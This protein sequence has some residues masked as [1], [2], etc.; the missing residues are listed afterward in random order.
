M[1]DRKKGDRTTLLEWL[2]F[3]RKLSSQFPPAPLRVLYSASGKIPAAALLR[4][5]AAVIEHKLYWAPVEREEEGLYLAAILNSDQAR[6]RVE[7]Q[8]SRGQ[9]GP[10]DFDNLLVELPIPKFDP[11]VSVHRALVAA[12]AEAEE[13]AAGVSIP[14]GTHFIRARRM[15]RDALEASGKASAIDAMVEGLLTGR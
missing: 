4:D 2:D 1:A 12:S 8:Q 13:V 11:S 3:Q 6:R 5:S 10:R 9:R 14:A 15:V 7:R